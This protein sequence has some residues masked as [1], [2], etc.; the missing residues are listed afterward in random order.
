MPAYVIS[1]AQVVDPS[2]WQHYRDLAASASALFGA[3]YVA[4]GA[5]PEFA[6]TALTGTPD[7]ATVTIIEFPS[8]AVVHE[9]YSSPE[10]APAKAIAATAAKRSLVFV[11]SV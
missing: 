6:D 3:R 1:I 10:Y 8:M 2:A 4:R 9:W 7:G 5:T 11:E